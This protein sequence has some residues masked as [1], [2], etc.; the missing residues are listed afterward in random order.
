MNDAT[1]QPAE[2]QQPPICPSCNADPLSF[3][4]THIKVGNANVVILFCV[5]CRKPF[6][7]MFLGYDQPRVVQPNIGETQRIIVPS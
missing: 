7:S 1:P 5:S 4:A 6:P 3:R 2:A